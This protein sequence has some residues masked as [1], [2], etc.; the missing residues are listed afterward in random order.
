MAAYRE[1]FSGER[2]HEDLW[3]TISVTVVATAIVLVLAMAIAL[4]LRLRGGFLARSLSVL[5]VVPMFILRLPVR[6]EMREIQQHPEAV[7]A[8]RARMSSPVTWRRTFR[9]GSVP[10]VGA[11]VGVRLRNVMTLIDGLRVR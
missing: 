5:A 3:V 11:R 8:P 9:T 7:P 10:A 1:V 4:F 2:F 6:E